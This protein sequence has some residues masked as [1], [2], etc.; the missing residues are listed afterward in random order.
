MQ[1]CTFCGSERSEYAKFCGYCGHPFS[2]T[3]V[4]ATDRT[5]PSGVDL[6]TLR[7][8]A[9]DN[10]PPG[11]NSQDELS[12]ATTLSPSDRGNVQN[13]QPAPDP[14][15]DEQEAILLDVPLPGIFPGQG[16]A[17]PGNVPMVQGTPQVNN[18]PIVHGSP[19]TSG[20]PPLTQAHGF[21][22]NP[23]PSESPVHHPLPPSAFHQPSGQ[24]PLHNPY[25]PSPQPH[26]PAEPITNPPPVHHRHEAHAHH[27]SLTHP[28]S[29]RPI[30]QRRHKPSWKVHSLHNH[31]WIATFLI[32]GTVAII[33]IASGIS[34]LLMLLPAS[35][36]IL[37]SVSNR[38]RKS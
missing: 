1:H 31:G 27:G 16:Q 19:P 18:V 20:T 15:K 11:A 21:Y 4:G 36:S 34:A 32:V 24:S 2:D 28:G 14:R 6:S 26:F 22:S 3:Q 7:A 23:A 12:S 30:V 5:V 13:S 17:L 10:A 33:I 29:R 25:G 38:D 37:S 35:L 9:I 8:S